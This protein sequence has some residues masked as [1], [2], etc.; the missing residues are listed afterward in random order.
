MSNSSQQTDYI[1]ISDEVETLSISAQDLDNIT[2]I[3]LANY[4]N[5]M[6]SGSYSSSY[7]MSPSISTITISPLSAGEIDILTHSNIS[8][9]L[10]EPLVDWKDKFPD[11]ERVLDM[12][13]QYPGL[14]IAF[15]KFR[16]CYEMVK[17]DYDNPAPKK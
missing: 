7:V 5:N 6:A 12:C 3:N 1:K 9:D 15:D 16:H 10:F 17:D 8:V 13:E 11:I 2:H 4:D 14:K